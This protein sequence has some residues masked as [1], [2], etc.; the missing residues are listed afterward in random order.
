MIPHLV[1]TVRMTPPEEMVGKFSAAVKQGM[2]DVLDWWHTKRLPV[3]FTLEGE[4]VYYLRERTANYMKSPRKRAHPEPLVYTGM[5]RSMVTK[6]MTR[7]ATGTRFTV[8]RARALMPAPFY[9]KFR[10][11]GWPGPLREE[12]TRLGKEE[13]H[14]AARIVAKSVKA[15]YERLTRERGEHAEHLA[16]EGVGA[17]GMRGKFELD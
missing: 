6:S 14:T 5:L 8:F 1:W 2:L 16:A 12:V 10:P 11:E 15:T 9:V 17:P 4:K 7:S 13:P 3:H